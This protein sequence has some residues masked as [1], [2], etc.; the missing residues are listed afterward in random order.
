MGEEVVEKKAVEFK[1][2]GEFMSLSV[3]P[4]KDGKPIVELKVHLKEV[5][6]ELLSAL[7]K[8]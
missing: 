5:P 2:E 3:D 6:A 1:F 7:K 4:N 8:D